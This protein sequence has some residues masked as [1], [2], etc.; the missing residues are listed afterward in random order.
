MEKE[1]FSLST[2]QIRKSGKYKFEIVLPEGK[3]EPIF[4]N[5]YRGAVLM[6]MEYGKGTKV[7]HLKGG[8]K[9]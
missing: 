6:A 4:T 3:G 8:N 2:E 5:D 7:V 9:S 1:Y